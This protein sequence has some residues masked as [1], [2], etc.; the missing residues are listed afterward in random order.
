MDNQQTDQQQN[1]NIQGEQ[2]EVQQQQQQE[3]IEQIQKEKEKC[4]ELKNKAGLLFSQQKFE[5]AAD[6]YNEAIDYCPL[7][8]LNM[9][10]ILNSNIAICLM[11]Q[12][13]YESALEHCSKALEFNPEFVKALLNRA[14]CYE[15]TDKLEE[16]LEDYKKLKELQPKDNAIMKK[17]IDL[18]LK[19]QE[20]Q[21][22]RKNEAL[23]GLKDLGNTLL[24]KFGLSLDNF[25]MQQN[26]NGSYNIQFQQ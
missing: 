26:E 7:E 8:D 17:Y 3:Q 20:L 23:K 1:Q 15:K 6:I 10:C 13:D 22:K 5:E 14:E 24:G 19:V 11:K 25:K 21:E 9:L 16:A 18:D 12:S 2:E 4:L